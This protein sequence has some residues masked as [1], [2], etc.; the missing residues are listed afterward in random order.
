MGCVK[1]I[2]TDSIW[3]DIPTVSQGAGDCIHCSTSRGTWRNPRMSC[4][5]RKIISGE[6]ISG[7]LGQKFGSTEVIGHF[8]PHDMA[9]MMIFRD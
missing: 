2:K 3:S 7:Q 8:S 5:V 9:R 1:H 6:D 4:S